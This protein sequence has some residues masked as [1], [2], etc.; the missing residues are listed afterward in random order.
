[1][2]PPDFSALHRTIIAA[3][4]ALCTRRGLN[5]RP[6]QRQMIDAIAA[7]LHGRNG[8][9]RIIAVEGPTG[10]G[11]TLAYLLGTIPVAKA[12]GKK[13]VVATATVALQEQL[14]HRDIPDLQAH[15]GL[16][17]SFALALGRGRFA[18]VTHLEQLAGKDSGQGNLFADLPPEHAAPWS[19]KPSEQETALVRTLL[20][21]LQRREW[22]GCR[23][24]LTEPM[25]DRLWSELTTDANRCVGRRC[26]NAAQCPF[27]NAR[28]GLHEA[29]VVVANH[30]LVLADMA[31]GGGILPET[32]ETFLVF[33][34]GHHLATK[35][36]QRF[37]A[38][39][40]LGGFVH[41]LERVNLVL[42]RAI[43][44]IPEPAESL[45]RAVSDAPSLVLE[46]VRATRALDTAARGLDYPKGG[47]G[48]AVEGD[49]VARMPLGVLPGPLVELAAALLA[50]VEELLKSAD[51]LRNGLAQSHK[52]GKGNLG[53]IEAA[54]PHVG[55]AC[56]RLQ[57]AV[58]LLRYLAE[59]D[60]PGALPAARWFR[61]D[62]SEVVAE[63][64][65]ISA[66]T[67]LRQSL[68]SR[69]AGAVITSATL[70]ALGT[71]D[72]LTR[73]C[74][75]GRDDGTQYLKLPSP[76]DYPNRARLVVAHMDH[77][78]TNQAA[79]LAEVA[80]QLPRR[81]HPDEGTLVLFTARRAMEQVAEALP[82]GWRARLLVQGRMGKQ[83][84][85]DAHRR[86]ID[87]GRGS[88]LFG[89]AS[90]AEGVDL[91]GAYCRHVVIVKLPF[92]VPDSPVE[93]T[94][95]EYVES[96]GG[97]AFLRLAVPD[98][99]LKL[100]QACGRLLRTEEDYGRV[101][102]FDRRLVTRRYGKLLLD[103]LP[104]FA[105]EIETAADARGE[106]S[107]L[108]G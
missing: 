24:S 93:A 31:S 89:L 72:R 86:A 104:P 7:T 84:L 81:L 106:N 87:A 66:A 40:A 19:R 46:A 10:T 38:R 98:T 37:Q 34:E 83:A 20:E 39:L 62:G 92:A 99:S 96:R 64:S 67:L 82:E 4:D 41:E 79:F 1:M 27:L 26:S 71:F 11:K 108:R 3:Y 5:Q 42:S 14:V 23:D 36:I 94:Q 21:R 85:L 48:R 16:D 52:Q 45:N 58:D 97:N 61:R 73:S 30:D 43:G 78:P 70:T 69:A 18:C 63:A 2:S 103:A 90:M 88:I 17:F 6:Q 68:W 53:R 25:D 49:A 50:P 44:E 13:V 80:A 74:G 60:A 28:Q 107:G 100:I 77:E 51:A 47:E 9:S 56:G 95:A 12:L 65:P 76:F 105:M 22:N 57:A 32:E 55:I 8:D 101:T 54:L 29:D 35:A 91:R 75:L 102:L 33:D 15:S 59:P